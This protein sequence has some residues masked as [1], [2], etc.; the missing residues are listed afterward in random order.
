M[1]NNINCRKYVYN[2]LTSFKTDIDINKFNNDSIIHN[3][4]IDY[5]LLNNICISKHYSLKQILEYNLSVHKFKSNT[6]DS[7]EKIKLIS[8][9]IEKNILT[10]LINKLNNNYKIIQK[11]TNPEIDIF[12]K[13]IGIKDNR[14]LCVFNHFTLPIFR[15]KNHPLYA[16]FLL[17]LNINNKLNFAIIEYD[18]PTHDNIHDFRFR[19]EILI[20]DSI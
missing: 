16:D 14:I 3:I 18:G 10:E 12:N 2:I 20:G 15:V 1:V 11:F 4:Y 13:L 7:I 8:N 5:N 6:I 19:K 17:L 9:D